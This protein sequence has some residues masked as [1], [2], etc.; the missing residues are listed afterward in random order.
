[1]HIPAG[2]ERYTQRAAPSDGRRVKNAYDEE[3]KMTAG[4][5][6]VGLGAVAAG[7]WWWRG[8]A[9]ALTNRLRGELSS[10][11]YGSERDID[12]PA[13]IYSNTP[14]AESFPTEPRQM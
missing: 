13:T 5:M 7:L 2:N 3:A 6:I 10:R 8:R 1:L 9:T 4:K 12:R 14:S 11:G